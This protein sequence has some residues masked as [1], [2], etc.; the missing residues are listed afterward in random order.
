M[1][2]PMLVKFATLF[3]GCL[4]VT[5]PMI[6]HPTTHKPN[7]IGNP[8][9]FIPMEGLRAVTVMIPNMTNR[10]PNTICVTPKKWNE[11]R[12]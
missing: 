7:K 5:T 8:I 1:L 4:A 6:P 2:R 10:I 12:N 11:Q 9:A 3:V